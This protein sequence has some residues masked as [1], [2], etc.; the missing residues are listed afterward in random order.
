MAFIFRTLAILALSSAALAGHYE[1]EEASHHA[2]GFS[3]AKFS[4]PVSGPEHKIEVHD[5]HGHASYDYVGHP[6]YKFEYGVEDPKSHVSQKRQ[7]HRDGDDV[8]GEYT[9]AQPDGKI[10]TVKYTSDKHNGFNA[11][12]YIDGKPLHQDVLEEQQAH[13]AAQAA[14]AANAGH[15]S[16][17]YHNEVV[18]EE[19]AHSYGGGE[20]ASY[21]GYEGGAEES[22][23]GGH[24]YY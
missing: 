17:D 9:V 24:E 23:E 7:E 2:P 22:V 15:G 1:E 14:H 5:K 11:E 19:P 12:V 18:H 16:D 6:S 20:E 8:H 13:L 3:Y 10:R 4:G 21:G